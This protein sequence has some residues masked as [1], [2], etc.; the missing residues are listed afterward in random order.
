[1]AP[2][3]L[4]SAGERGY[5][6]FARTKEM[7]DTNVFRQPGSGSST[8]RSGLNLKLLWIF[9]VCLLGGVALSVLHANKKAEDRRSLVRAETRARATAL[10]MELNSA[11]GAADV[12]GA[13]VRQGGGRLPNFQSIAGELIASHPGVGS[14]TLEPAGVVSDIAP[15]SGNE[16]TIGVNVLNDP[17]TGAQAL[18]AR[19]KAKLTVVGPLRLP[20]GGLGIVGRA[21]VFLPGRDGRDTFWG[22]VTVSVR[23]GDAVRRARLDELTAGNCDFLLFSPER[24]GRAAAAIVGSGK[25]LGRDSVQQAVQAGDLGLRLAVHPRDGWFNT[26]G[27]VEWFGGVA[28]LAALLTCLVHV[29]ARLKATGNALAGANDQAAREREEVNRTKA[30]HERLEEELSRVKAQLVGGEEQLGRAKEELAGAKTQLAAAEEQLHREREEG[31]Q[32]KEELVREKE[33]SA[34]ATEELAREKEEFAKAKEELDRLQ[35]KLSRAEAQLARDQEQLAQAKEELAGAKGQLAETSEQLLRERDEG[36]RAKEELAREKERVVR[37]KE[38]VG[39]A[40]AQFAE[41]DEQ[42]RR[43]REEA[44]RAKAELVREQ[45]QLRG[46]LE[47]SL[48]ARKELEKQLAKTSEELARQRAQALSTDRAPVTSPPQ[49][50]VAPVPEAETTA[51]A[52]EN[53][54][55]EPPPALAP[56]KPAK[57]KKE[58]E[59]DQLSLFGEPEASKRAARAAEVQASETPS[60]TPVTEEPASTSIA[61]H[62][63]GNVTERSAGSQPALEVEPRKADKMSALPRNAGEK[64]DLAGVPSEPI[65]LGRQI[66]EPVS[67]STNARSKSESRE[68]KEEKPAERPPPP[69]DPPVLRKA[70]NEI[71]PLLTELDP[72]AAECLRA[73]RRTFRSAFSVEGFADFEQQV[74][75]GAYHEALELLKKAAKKQ[76]VLR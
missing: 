58:R 71:L 44:A 39:G 22:F 27:I 33:Q 4:S 72:G 62:E 31:A 1:M 43:E 57:R 17:A 46:E 35:K 65:R 28:I 30:A 52:L 14:L 61:H 20:P 70:V 5:N 48:R 54:A 12:L 60:S 64:G 3:E 23:L 47:E 66:E 10:E 68:E 29:L 2:K 19:Q 25:P 15:R 74:K 37:A 26:R 16:R 67:E 41:A 11:L 55:S 63:I 40:K 50:D 38:Q 75:A 51:P 8:A 21:P 45:K 18:A 49:A 42:L 56:P 59:T 76:G 6:G 53:R 69:V 9:A 24:P 13:L 7:S 73:N 32:A 34:R 36:T